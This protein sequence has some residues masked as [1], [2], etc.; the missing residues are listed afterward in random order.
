MLPLKVL[1]H[2]VRG[3]VVGEVVEL[4]EEV[5]VQEFEQLP[6]LH[7]QCL[8][9]CQQ[10]LRQHLLIPVLQAQEVK[11]LRRS[12]VAA[13][14]S[15]VQQVVHG[16]NPAAGTLPANQDLLGDSV[17]VAGGSGGTQVGVTVGAATAVSLDLQE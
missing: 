13:A 12:Q 5:Q 7:G 14:Q 16:V 17:S 8:C 9:Q 1:A 15:L 6:V 10:V 3:G 4:D 2:Q 11:Q